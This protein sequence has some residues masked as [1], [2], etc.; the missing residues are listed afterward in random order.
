MKDW[1]TQSLM[2]TITL[3]K[4]WK[5]PGSFQVNFRKMK[6]IITD[7]FAVFWQIQISFSFE[8]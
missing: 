3:R 4:I 6:V 5:T 8:N 7:N 2:N 1:D